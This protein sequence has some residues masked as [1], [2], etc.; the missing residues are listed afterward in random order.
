MTTRR[1]VLAAGAGVLA[2]PAVRAQGGAP[3]RLGLLTVKS[4]PLAS[5]GVQME[6]GLVLFLKERGNA[7]LGR[8][9]EL[10]IADTGGAPAQAR[11]KT[12]ELVERNRVHAIIGPL[13]AFEALAIDDYIRQ[14]QTPIIACS[15]AAEDLTQRSPN[16]WFVRPVGT[17][18]QCT[19][20]LADYAA[21]ELKYKRIAMVADDFAYGHEQTAGFQRVFEDAGGRVVQ[22][23][24]PPLSVPDYGTYISQIKT[25]TDAVFAG[26]AG[27]NGFRFIRQFN[28]YGLAGRLPLLGGMTTTDESILQNMGNEAVGAVTANWYSAEID[29]PL[30][31][32][33]VEQIRRDHKQDPGYY[34]AGTHVSATLLEHALRAVDGRIEDKPAFMAALRGAKVEDTVR[35]PIRF[36]E[37][38]Q[39]VGTVYV[40]R[41]ER[42][43]GRLVNAVVKTYPD[44][45]QFWTYDPA[46]FLRQPVYGRNAPPAR[47]LEN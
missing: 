18:A 15:A 31:R 7:L 26:F 39:S 3:I 12:Q 30:N 28:E 13:A 4:G 33:F 5:G 1:M 38:G 6:N 47:F 45:S 44:V 8:P 36:D 29:T 22:K 27:S 43:G 40:R 32:R 41:V 16:P 9:V 34:S 25:N 11:T 21:K 14:T 24:W 2:A 35:G 37:Y 46:E 20:P 42:K 19:Q 10:T 17:S 23:L